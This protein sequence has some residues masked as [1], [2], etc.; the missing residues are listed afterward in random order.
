[1]REGGCGVKNGPRAERVEESSAGDAAHERK[2][3]HPLI[4]RRRVRKVAATPRALQHAGRAATRAPLATAAA[5]TH[6]E[7]EA[8]GD[9]LGLVPAAVRDGNDVLLRTDFGASSPRSNRRPR[10]RRASL[11]RTL[12][13]RARPRAPAAPRTRSAARAPRARGTDPNSTHT[14]RDDHG[15]SEDDTRSMA[16]L[17]VLPLRRRCG[18]GGVVRTETTTT[19]RPASNPQR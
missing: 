1:M 7:A 8:P 11:A 4:T 14:H 5:E 16:P 19:D 9:E 2:K 15:R 18:D 6:V 13:P 12:P 17:P 10:A 3:D